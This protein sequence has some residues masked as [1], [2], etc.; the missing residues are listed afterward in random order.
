MGDY[1]GVIIV[2]SAHFSR[3]VCWDMESGRPDKQTCLPVGK[4]PDKQVNLFQNLQ[5][6]EKT[7]QLVCI[8]FILFGLHEKAYI[9][10]FITRRM[11]HM[12]GTSDSRDGELYIK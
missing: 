8:S 1:D 11:R 12:L 5:N 4:V 6:Y 2:K 9:P 7:I 10:H 3:G